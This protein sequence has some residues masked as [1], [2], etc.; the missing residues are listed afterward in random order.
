MNPRM[1]PVHFFHAAMLIDPGASACFQ[2]AHGWLL[3]WHGEWEMK[4]ISQDQIL[5]S[6]K[7]KT[8]R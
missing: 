1:P 2:G 7:N 3:G 8:K 5:K 6:L 4:N